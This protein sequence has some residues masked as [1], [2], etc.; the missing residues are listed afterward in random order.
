MKEV[1]LYKDQII[2]SYDRGNSL[3]CAQ[4]VD[5]FREWEVHRSFIEEPNMIMSEGYQEMLGIGKRFRASFSK[6]LNNLT[7][8]DYLFT[9]TFGPRTGV[10]IEAFVEGFGNENYVIQKPKYYQSTANVS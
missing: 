3:L 7:E 5:N 8:E 9:P 4:D 1:M 10:S 6:L 2:S